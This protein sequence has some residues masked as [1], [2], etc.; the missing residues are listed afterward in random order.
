MSDAPGRPLI[1]ALDTATRLATVALGDGGPH[2]LALRTWDAGFRHGRELLASL[3]AMLVDASVGLA[4][5]DAV[6]V[7]TG[8]GA[9]TGL[10]VGLATAKGLAHALALPIVAVPSTMAIACA[11]RRH[12][13]NA[14]TSPSSLADGVGIIVI[15]PAGPHDRYVARFRCSGAGTPVETAPARILPAGATLG[16][17]ASGGVVIVAV[18]VAASADVPAAAVDLGRHAQRGLGHA[19]LSLGRAALDRGTTDDVASLVPA[20]VTLPR[21]VGEQREEVAWSRDHR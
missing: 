11:A 2:V 13:E 4:D 3:D 15:L 18:D 6:V 8:P 10:R 19:L 14:A 16:S 5:I 17:D 20:Y 1:L 21:G 9:F 7:G 12:I